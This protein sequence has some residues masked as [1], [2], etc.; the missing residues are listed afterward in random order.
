MPH[1]WI[2]TTAVLVA[3]NGA[4][5]GTFLVVR[6]EAMVGEAIAHAVLP[7]IVLAFLSTGH[8]HPFILLLGAVCTSLLATGS[9]VLLQQYFQLTKDSAL[10]LVLTIF[11]AAGIALISMF[12]HR[13]DMDQDCVFNGEVVYLPFHAVPYGV[14]LH[15]PP[16]VVHLMGLTLFNSAWIYR[17]YRVLRVVAFDTTF[18]QS[19]GI[20]THYWYYGLMVLTTLTVVISFRAVGSML[21]VALLILPPASAYLLTHRLMMVGGLAIWIGVLAAVGGCA[22]AQ[23]GNIT[24]AGAIVTMASMLFGMAWAAKH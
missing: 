2:I 13:V 10:S 7:G 20:R 24:V 22:L 4:L 11:F 6:H 23:V 12:T 21:V 17:Y 14:G 9:I 1:Y 16:L 3:I 8:T 19:I 5:L 18:A 15:I